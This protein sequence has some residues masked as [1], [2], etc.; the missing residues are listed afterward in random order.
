MIAF[1]GGAAEGGARVATPE[2]LRAASVEEAVSALGAE[3]LNARPL[4][5]GQSLIPLINLG[6]AQPDL[7]VDIGHI[8]ELTAVVPVEGMTQI[9]ACATY[10]TTAAA[11]RGR[12]P[13]LASAIASVG[14]TRVRN[15]GT[16]G[17]SVAHAD[18]SAETPLALAALNATYKTAGPTGSRTLSARD[19]ALGP[20]ATR[21]EPGELVVAIEIPSTPWETGWG[22]QEFSRRAGD[23]AI[24]AAAA[25]ARCADGRVETATVW[26]AGVGGGPVRCKTLEAALPGVAVSDVSGLASLVSED[27]APEDDPF[28][29]ASYRRHVAGVIAIRA[30][31]DACRRSSEES[32]GR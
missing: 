7:L 19:F 25:T 29:P 24:V 28:V 30:L 14:S 15:M 6:L 20:Y 11:V 2:Y 32:R 4:A 13:L 9:G 26:L 31:Q 27:L 8:S 23:F 10:V 5:G 3:D 16:I 22:F 17:G 1:G 12:H 21:L 18:P